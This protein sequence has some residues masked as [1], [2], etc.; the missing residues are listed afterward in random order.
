MNDF[1]KTACF[2]FDGVCS[3]YDKWRGVDV[4]GDPI[5]ETADL[6]GQ[7]RM[8]GWRV[9]L[10]TTR[11]MTPALLEWLAHHNFN[12]DSINACDHNPPETSMKPIAEIYIDDRGFRFEQSNPLFSCEKISLMLGLEYREYKTL[13]SPDR[14]QLSHS[15]KMDIVCGPAPNDRTYQGK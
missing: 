3:T 10:W 9:I 2:D 11:K 6:V 5:R 15:E 7:F 4:F 12:F 1:K 8:N 13:L 14:P